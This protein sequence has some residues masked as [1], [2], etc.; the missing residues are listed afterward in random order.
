M[1]DTAKP[2]MRLSKHKKE[3]DK[4]QIKVMS[5][6]S[7]E[8][9]DIEMAFNS[10]AKRIKRSLRQEDRDELLDEINALVGRFIRDARGR[11][12]T[13][14]DIKQ[15][16]NFAPMPSVANAAAITSL[17]STILP[18]P[19]PPMM[20]AMPALHRMETYNYEGDMSFTNL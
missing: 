7:E 1:A 19:P 5:V 12:A 13:K 17:V 8:D 14:H 20:Q 16:P 3:A 2:P 18:P 11:N 6:L 4:L 9:D 10:I 15:I